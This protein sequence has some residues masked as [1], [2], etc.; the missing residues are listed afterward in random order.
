MFVNL[1]RDEIAVLSNCI[2]ETFEAVDDF[3]LQ[4]RIGVQASDLKRLRE[5]LIEA[6]S[7]DGA[8]GDVD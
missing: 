4:S 3:E 6:L 2:T 1:S 8:G 5:K 7:L